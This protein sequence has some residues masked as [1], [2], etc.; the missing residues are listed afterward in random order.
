MEKR[1]KRRRAILKVYF[2]KNFWGSGEDGT[3]MEEIRLNQSF[4][5]EDI[6]GFI[7][8]VYVDEEG[9][10][11]DFCI[12][13]SNEK[14]KYFWDKWQQKL[15]ESSEEDLE[16]IANENPLNQVDFHVQVAVN[17]E[18]LQNEFGCGAS[19]TKVFGNKNIKDS[20]EEQL[21]LAYQCDENSSWHFKRH[22]CRWSEKPQKIEEITI[23]FLAYDKRLKCD[24]L[25]I[26]LADAGKEYPLIHPLSGAQY[27]LCVDKAEQQTLPKFLEK[28]SDGLAYQEV[29]S[30]FLQITYH[31]Q[32][33]I[34]SS[35]FLLQCAQK[36]DKPHRYIAGREANVTVIGS[37]DGPTSIFLA[38]RIDKKQGHVAA[39]EC[40]YEPIERMYWTPIFMAKERQNMTLS[41]KLQ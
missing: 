18:P 9:I 38:G 5:W 36:G 12:R 29:P 25:E 26:G 22:I 13:V 14:L 28:V 33:D 23:D 34:P 1:G 37:T 32:P 30:H 31:M 41:I 35:A 39:S 20:L 21:F 4:L 11:I 7:P 3:E 40:F 6:S 24:K 19:Y 15:E 16:Q 8:S 27:V 2:G 10:A 17:G